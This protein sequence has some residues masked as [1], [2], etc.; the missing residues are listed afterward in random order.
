MPQPEK[1]LDP[2]SSPQEWFGYEL[3]LRRKAEGL[4]ARALGRLVQVS[5]DMILSVEKGQYPS[6]QREVAQ[7]LDE[8]LRTGGVFDRSWPMVFGRRDADKKPADADKRS[9]GRRKATV[10]VREGRILG[11]DEVSPRPGSQ[12]SVDRRVFL[13]VSGLAAI[14]PVDLAQAFAPSGLTLPESIGARDVDQVQEVAAAV[15]GWDNKYGGGGMVGDVAGRAM[16]WAAGLLQTRCPEHLRSD[17][18]AAVSRLGI[19]VGASAFDFYN[20]DYATKT[21]TFAADCAEEAGDWHLRAKSYSFLA[22][23]AVWIGRPDD[24]LTYAEKGLVRSDRLTATERAMLHTARARAFGKL[25][26]VRDCMAAVGEADEAFAQARPADDPPWM[27]YYD[28]AQH[29]GDTAHALFDLAILAGQD[30]GRAARRFATAVKGHSDAFKR[31]RAISRTKLA[32]LIMAK[33]DPRQAA[34]IGHDAL[35]EAGRLTSRRAADD[36][37]Q[38]GAFAGKHPAVGEAQA[39]RERIAATVSV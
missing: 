29:N 10:Q 14:A 16:Q 22:R 9:G 28:E 13:H 20:H 12:E 6:C 3:R 17:L 18:F 7:R 34:V 5:D 24:G 11:R 19:V 33:G 35:D 38:L 39:L 4:S 31:S 15:S 23:Q 8:V 1:P 25:G 21:F 36:L 2:G 27:A 30:P 32:A 26:N 37:R